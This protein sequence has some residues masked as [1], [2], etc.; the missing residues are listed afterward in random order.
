MPTCWI[1]AGPNGAGKTTFV[2]FCLRRPNDEYTEKS[3]PF[4]GRATTT[5]ITAPGG[6]QCIGKKTAARSL[7][8]DLAGRPASQDR[9]RH[10]GPGA[11]AMKAAS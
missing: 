8:R 1:I 4:A 9:G 3:Q 10:T 2:S 5:G 7:R 6:E 11:N